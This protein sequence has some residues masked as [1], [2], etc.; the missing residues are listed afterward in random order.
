VELA[1]PVSIGNL[2]AYGYWFI[3]EGGSANSQTYIMYMCKQNIVESK[4]LSGFM[5]CGKAY[6]KPFLKED[7]YVQKIDLLRCSR[8]DAEHGR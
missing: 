5:V 1:V 3:K 6:C 4:R 2:N 8:S 7:H